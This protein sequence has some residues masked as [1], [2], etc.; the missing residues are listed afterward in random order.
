MYTLSLGDHLVPPHPDAVWVSLSI[1]DREDAFQ[2]LCA[3][4]DWMYPGWGIP[5]PL[6]T[7]EAERQHY[8][9]QLP[10]GVRWEHDEP[11]AFQALQEE[12]I[13]IDSDVLDHARK[14]ALQRS[15]RP[16]LRVIPTSAVSGGVRDALLSL[17]GVQLTPLVAWSAPLDVRAW[18]LLAER[19][20]TGRAPCV[21]EIPHAGVPRG[22]VPQVLQRYLGWSQEKIAAAFLPSGRLTQVVFPVADRVFLSVECTHTEDSCWALVR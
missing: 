8:V 14:E 19:D 3:A 12:E 20:T 16:F 11:E 15:E 13:I 6:R 9:I 22:V 2:A 10:R 1:E 21:A 4:L 7:W 17:D 5:I 18:E